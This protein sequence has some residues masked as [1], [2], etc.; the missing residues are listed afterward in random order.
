[1]DIVIYMNEEDFKHKTGQPSIHDDES[2]PITAH[3]SMKRMPRRFCVGDEEDRIWLAAAGVVQG[4]VQTEGFNP[5]DEYGENLVWDSRTFVQ[6]DVPI[7]CK[8]FRGFRYRWWNGEKS[9]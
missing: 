7:P 4:S 1:M 3:W 9:V 5:D 8:P 6:L 2:G